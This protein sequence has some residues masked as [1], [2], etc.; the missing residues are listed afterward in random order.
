MTVRHPYDLEGF[1]EDTP[2]VSGW[3]RIWTDGDVHLRM[4][5]DSMHR[6]YLSFIDRSYFLEYSVQKIYAETIV[7]PLDPLQVINCSL[8]IYLFHLLIYLILQN[9]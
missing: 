4:G 9:L 3:I 2:D 7:F 6:P 8:Q 5:L 1:V